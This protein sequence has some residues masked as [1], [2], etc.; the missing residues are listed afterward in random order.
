MARMLVLTGIVLA[1]SSVAA[2]EAD[3]RPLPVLYAPATAEAGENTP[4]ILVQQFMPVAPNGES[5]TVPVGTVVPM[6]ECPDGW[7]QYKNKDDEP[8]FFPFGL[9]VDRHGKPSVKDYKLLLACQK[10][11]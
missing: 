11:K 2:Q 8:L 7:A 1:V 6:S 3:V 9:V 4:E 5:L 10:V